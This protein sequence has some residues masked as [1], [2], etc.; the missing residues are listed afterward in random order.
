MTRLTSFKQVVGTDKFTEDKTFEDF[1]EAG[2]KVKPVSVR[3]EGSAPMFL[4]L[5]D[6]SIIGYTLAV[7]LCREE[8]LDGYMISISKLGD[9]YIKGIGDGKLDNNIA[10][11]P[12]F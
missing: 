10:N 9:E 4:K 8:L 2:R 5:D 7:E 3:F 12:R 11:L 1:K 6:G